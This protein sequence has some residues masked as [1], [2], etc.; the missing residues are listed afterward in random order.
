MYKKTVMF[1]H[2][3]PAGAESRITID[4]HYPLIKHGKVQQKKKKNRNH[5]QLQ[6]STVSQSVNVGQTTFRISLNCFMPIWVRSG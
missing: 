6:N 3:A 4:G 5:Q 1:A 2:S